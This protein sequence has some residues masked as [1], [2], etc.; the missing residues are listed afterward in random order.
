MKECRQLYNYFL[1]IRRERDQNKQ[2]QPT[3]QE[4]TNLLLKLKEEKPQ[5]KN[6]FSQVLQNIPYHRVNETWKKY[7]E[8]KKIDFKVGYPRFKLKGWYDSFT[9]PQFGFKLEK[10]QLL[11]I[12]PQLLPKTGKV[13]GIDMGITSFCATSDKKLYDKERKHY[14]KAEKRIIKSQ[15]RLSRR[16]K[17]SNEQFVNQRKHET[18]QVVN[19][20]MKNYD[21]IARE[22]L[23]IKNMLKNHCL[24]KKI[25]NAM[26]ET[27]KKVVKVNPRNTSQICSECDKQREPKLKLSQK[28]FNCFHCG[29]KENRDINASRNILKNA[30]EEGCGTNLWGAVSMEAV[31]NHEFSTEKLPSSNP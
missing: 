19:D 10:G 22:D 14:K 1:E 30:C 21:V 4:Q 20:L 5:L 15:R 23:K 26:E 24:A 7:R 31:K 27:G 6:I 2:K 17:D 13:V 3:K 25:T 9:Y 29:Y 16:T 8:K 18:Y 28:K 11:L 12:E